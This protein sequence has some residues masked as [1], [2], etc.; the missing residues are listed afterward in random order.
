MLVSDKVLL[1]HRSGVKNEVR[2]AP[3]LAFLHG[4]KCWE[5]MHASMQ[6]RNTGVR[7]ASNVIG[8]CEFLQVI[9]LVLHV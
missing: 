4:E 9:F 1:C 3:L 7:M 8:A 2:A 5:Q 6:N